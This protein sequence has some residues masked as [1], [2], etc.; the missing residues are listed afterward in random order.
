MSGNPFVGLSVPFLHS[1]QTLG[2]VLV[3]SQVV[4]GSDPALHAFP[5]VVPGQITHCLTAFAHWM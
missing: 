5:S 3:P 1:W 2:E 4:L